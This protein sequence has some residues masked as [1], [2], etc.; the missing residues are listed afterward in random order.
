M[1]RYMK[2]QTIEEF[3]DSIKE[4]YIK[5]DFYFDEE[6][7]TSIEEMLMNL[8]M[9]GEGECV[10]MSKLIKD[11]WGQFDFG[12]A[13]FPTKEELDSD[14]EVPEHFY[15]RK[16]QCAGFQSW[17]GK[18]FYGGFLSS[19]SGNTMFVA[20]YQDNKGFLRAYIPKKGNGLN[21]VGG[22]PFDYDEDAINQ[23][24]RLK[25]FKDFDD[26]NEN[27]P[28]YIAELYDTELIKQEI[29]KRFALK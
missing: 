24:A 4:M 12:N 8:V 25:G 21:P 2:K 22:L 10:G 16:I 3:K 15:Y 14:E 9:A 17:E 29:L 23:Y 6:R 1:P 7:G 18:T 20:I 5:N 19:G 13:D 11:I 27:K 26:M 28:D